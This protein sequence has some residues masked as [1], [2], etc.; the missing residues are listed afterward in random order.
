MTAGTEARHGEGHARPSPPADEKFLYTLD[1]LRGI[2]M[3][4]VVLNHL[5]DLRI[6]HLM[7][8]ADRVVDLFFVLS[9]FV[10]AHVYEPRFAR[11]L[12]GAGFIRLRM[13]R[14]Y[15][16]YFLALVLVAVFTLLLVLAGHPIAQPGIFL[17]SLAIGLFVLPTTQALSYRHH[18]L[19]P[20]N[21]AAWTLLW[22]VLANILWA[23]IAPRLT[24]RVLAG[25]VLIGFV[26][27]LWGATRP[28]GLNGGAGFDNWQA[29]AVRLI[30]T[31]FGGLAAY[32]VWI[33]GG[34]RWFRIPAWLSAAILVAIVIGRPSS[35]GGL[36]DVMAILA[37]PPLVLASTRDPPPFIRAFVA[38]LGAVSYAVY[39]LHYPVLLF[40]TF[41]LARVGLPM[42]QLGMAGNALFVA[43]AFIAGLLADRY[44]D[45]PA[46]RW[47]TRRL[48]PRSRGN[49]PGDRPAAA[50]TGD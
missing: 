11:D 35:W 43:L 26:I 12:S 29:G 17:A 33:S 30:F 10:L 8:G 21:G 9:G 47:L 48:A 1:A 2:A 28:W 20:F 40:L 22:E 50:L 46:R 38:R 32:R 3:T 6:H 34:V 25:I 44:F 16:L 42:K 13:I 5:P 4:V 41:A 27:L 39:I 45:R 37:L 49:V 31:Y 7:P 18:H 23:A 36:Y 14:I 19:Y 15:P 24:N